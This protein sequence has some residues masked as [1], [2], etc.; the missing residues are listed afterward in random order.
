MNVSDVSGVPLYIPV[1]GDKDVCTTADKKEVEDERKSF[2]SGHTASVCAPAMFA[3]IY[4]NLEVLA[5]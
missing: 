1:V 4:I 5:T 3:L 2:P